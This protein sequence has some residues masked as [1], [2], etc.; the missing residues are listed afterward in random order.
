MSSGDPLKGAGYVFTP[1]VPLQV[2]NVSF[3]GMT[4]QQ[5][6]G[7]AIE[8]IVSSMLYHELGIV[9]L[10][11]LKSDVNELMKR[12]GMS[13]TEQRV[14]R[15]KFRKLWRKLARITPRHF[16]RYR[17]SGAPAGRPKSVRH[18]LRMLAPG[19]PSVGLTSE[20]RKRIV[21]REV[22]IRA[23]ELRQRFDRSLRAHEPG[24]TTG[25][26]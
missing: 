15:R 17:A 21:A 20:E 1:Y 10:E 6:S 25:A 12:A 4:P 7:R 5:S 23:A 8:Q 22:A 18:A 11:S 14:A 9:P 24:E 13:E 19:Y 26:R 2:T 16:R 3:T